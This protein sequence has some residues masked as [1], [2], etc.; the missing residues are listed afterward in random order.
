MI[1]KW[2]DPKGLALWKGLHIQHLIRRYRIT[3][4][5][6]LVLESWTP[7]EYL[8]YGSAVDSFQEFPIFSNVCFLIIG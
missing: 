8:F 5:L 7:K 3:D 1:C 6:S 4:T 2:S